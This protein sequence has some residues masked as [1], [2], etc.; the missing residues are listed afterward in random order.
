MTA[1]RIRDRLKKIIRDCKDTIVV[2]ESWA[3]NRPNE[4]P[5]DCEPERIMRDLASE[6]LRNFYAGGSEGFEAANKRLKDYVDQ[7]AAEIAE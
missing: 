4:R 2:A 3:D 6:C 7:I 5:L 1:K